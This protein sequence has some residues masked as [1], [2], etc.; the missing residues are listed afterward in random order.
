M[1]PSLSPQSSLL[2]LAQ[3]IVHTCTCS[4]EEVPEQNVHKI[5]LKI[6]FQGLIMKPTKIPGSNRER[7]RD[8]TSDS[9]PVHVYDR[10]AGQ[11][12]Q[13]ISC[14]LRRADDQEG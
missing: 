11:I 7:R 12:T 2:L 5:C 13:A 8:G 9:S 3:K 10:P 6:K 1:P 14:V 4:L